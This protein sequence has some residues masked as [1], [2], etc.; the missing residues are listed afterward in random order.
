MLTSN[1]KPYITKKPMLQT[2]KEQILFLSC[3]QKEIMKAVKLRFQ[4]SVG[5]GR[6]L[7][8]MC[9]Q[10][11]FFLVRKVDNKMTQMLDRLQLRRFTLRQPLLDVQITCQ[12][13]K[14]DPEVIFKHVHL[15]AR[16]WECDWETSIFDTDD[17][18]TIPVIH[19]K[20]QYDMTYHRMKRGVHQEPHEKV[21]QKFFSSADGLCD[22]TGTYQYTE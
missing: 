5:L 11:I 16:A 15:C 18:N 22:G 12:E 4:N 13:W 1:I 19:S 21:H 7:L 17:H 2:W 6:I 20:L 8:K 3:S 9:E 10:T 14:S